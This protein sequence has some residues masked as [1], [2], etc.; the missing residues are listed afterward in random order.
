MISGSVEETVY[1][2]AR[3][4]LARVSS[5]LA[6][7]MKPSPT[8][9]TPFD[10][11]WKKNNE[12][13]CTFDFD[14][15]SLYA[16]YFVRIRKSTDFS[17]VTF[18]NARLPRIE[19]FCIPHLTSISAHETLGARESKAFRLDLPWAALNRYFVAPTATGSKTIGFLS[20]F[21]HFPTP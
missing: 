19:Q 5:I 7:S 18:D 14:Y 13:S 17:C 12:T 9:S 6:G 3:S 20:V 10:F 21:T 4:F 16:T 2:D 8:L 1:G 11:T 15:A